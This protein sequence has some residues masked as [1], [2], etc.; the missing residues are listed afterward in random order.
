MSDIDIYQLG[1]NFIYSLTSNYKKY[2]DSSYSASSNI[3]NVINKSITDVQIKNTTKYSYIADKDLPIVSAYDTI[4]KHESIFL[5]VPIR[6]FDTGIRKIVQ[7][8]C[9]LYH[10]IFLENTGSVYTCGANTN[11]QLGLGDYENRSTFT[12][13]PNISDIVQIEAGTEETIILDNIGNV[14]ACGLNLNGQLGVGPDNNSISTPILVNCSNIVQ[15]KTSSS[16]RTYFLQNTGYVLHSGINYNSTYYDYYPTITSGL[17]NICQIAN[18]TTSYHSLFLDFFGNVFGIGANT[19]GQLGISLNYQHTAAPVQ[20]NISN[21]TQIA[22]GKS[23]SI[24]LNDKGQVYGCGNNALGQLG[25]S[26][27]IYILEYP[28]LLNVSNITSIATSQSQTIVIEDSKNVLACGYLKFG[29]LGFSGDIINNIFQISNTYINQ[30]TYMNI[31]NIQ[32]VQAYTYNTI[33]FDIEGNILVAGDNTY[34]Q[35]GFTTNIKSTVNIPG[36]TITYIIP[37]FQPI[38]YPSTLYA[39]N[40]KSFPLIQSQSKLYVTKNKNAKYQSYNYNDMFGVFNLNNTIYEDIS[41]NVLA[42]IIKAEV[43]ETHSVFLLGDNTVYA[44]GNNFYGQLGTN[45]FQKCFATKQITNN[46]I[47]IACGA[48]HTVLLKNDNTVLSCGRNTYGQLGVG[49]N[50]HRNNLSQVTS[51]TGTDSLSSINIIKCGD[52]HTM[53]STTTGNVLGCGQNSSGQLGINNLEDQNKP[54]YVIQ[55]ISKI[56]CGKNYTILSSASDVFYLCGSD[57]LLTTENTIMYYKYPREYKFKKMS[58]TLSRKLH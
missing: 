3:Q 48:F 13:I 2:Y 14:H 5:N 11:G 40:K 39:T 1:S 26:E 31:S 24:F 32:L 27:D 21:I 20:I 33:L 18:N 52:N 30:F 47:D 46:I 44:C 55:N 22:I 15:V 12:K 16:T 4:Q 23:H 36:N 53:F 6:Y 7:I 37:Y 51:T 56:V 19:F 10:C 45:N 29:Q 49:D 57:E 28:T 17:S 8:S 25:I 34:S 58:V 50:L 54:V 9:G 35:F 41:G 38:T 42:N 43:G